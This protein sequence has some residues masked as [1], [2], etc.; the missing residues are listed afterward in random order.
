MV[1]KA[2]SC[3]AVGRGPSGAWESVHLKHQVL[4]PEGAGSARTCFLAPENAACTADR[5]DVEPV[6]RP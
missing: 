5:R 1:K 6:R 4:C 3:V 2:Q